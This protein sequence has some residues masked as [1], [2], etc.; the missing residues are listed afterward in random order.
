MAPT[1]ALE[2]EVDLRRLLLRCEQHVDDADRATAPAPHLHT[3][4]TVRP[5]PCAGDLSSRLGQPAHPAVKTI[6]PPMD[7]PVGCG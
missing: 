4:R 7:N 3:V 5:S 2:L 6:V 1:L